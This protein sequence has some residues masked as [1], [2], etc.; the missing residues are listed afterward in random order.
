M[1]P[2]LSQNLV[3][4]LSNALSVSRRSIC[5]LLLVMG[6]LEIWMARPHQTARNGLIQTWWMSILCTCSLRRRSWSQIIIPW[7]IFRQKFVSGFFFQLGLYSTQSFPSG[8]P[9]SFY[10]TCGICGIMGR[11]PNTLT[12]IFLFCWVTSGFGMGGHNWH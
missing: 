4:E 10:I 11:T 1:S 9:S 5:D 12:L 6:V 3:R 8:L 2:T 7:T